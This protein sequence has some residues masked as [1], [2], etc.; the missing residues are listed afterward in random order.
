MGSLAL[1][2]DRPRDACI[3]VHARGT[4]PEDVFA[5]AALMLT[6]AL[7]DPAAAEELERV[8]ITCTGRDLDDLLMAWLDA[9]GREMARLQMLFVRVDLA[10]DGGCL[11]ATLWG[12]PVDAALHRPTVAIAAARTTAARVSREADGTYV[13]NATIALEEAPSARSPGL[14]AVAGV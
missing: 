2:T 1:V 4:S 10:V 14:V 7:V 6:G 13:A 9:V 12:E 5:A 8:A 11:R 3:D